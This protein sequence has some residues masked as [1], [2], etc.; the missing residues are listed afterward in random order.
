MSVGIAD[1]GSSEFVIEMVIGDAR[2]APSPEATPLV[3]GTVS[4]LPPNPPPPNEACPNLDGP[5]LANALNAP[6][7][8][9]CG[10]AN[11]DV[12]GADDG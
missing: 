8:G 10:V 7:A 4:V 9:C 11:G 3:E 12:E 2:G 6:P 5:A 1:I